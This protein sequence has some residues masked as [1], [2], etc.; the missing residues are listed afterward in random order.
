MDV[1]YNQHASHVRRKNRSTTNL[2][3]LSL[4][5][6]T[7]R[8][9]LDDGANIDDYHPE[10]LS[11]PPSYLQ[12]KSAPTTPRLLSR[13]PGPFP[14]PGAQSASH[15]RGTSTPTALPKAKSTTHLHQSATSAHGPRGPGQRRG[16]TGGVGRDDNPA[17]ADDTDWLLRAGALIY[18]ETRESKGQSWLV[19][20][21]SSVSLAGSDPERAG[22]EAQLAREREYFASRH[23]SRRG[24]FIG[25][26]PVYAS[27]PSAS[28]LGSRSQSRVGSRA[29]LMTPSERRRSVDGYFGHS[30][31]HHHPAQLEDEDDEDASYAAGPDFVSLDTKLEA[32][33]VDTSYEDEAHVR[34][35]VKDGGPSGGN[36]LGSVLRWGLF[37]VEENEEESDGEGDRETTGDDDQGE[38]EAVK[39]PTPSRRKSTVRQFETLPLPAEERVPPPKDDEGGWQDAA[40]LLSVASRVLL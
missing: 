37:S 15:T 7:S 11:A 4:A 2:N 35:L 29:G 26:E 39:F 24:S 6:L 14:R 12:G 23:A 33:E 38:G 28:R 27:S 21:A 22:E 5:P 30:I 8:L 18:T 25:D 16:K 31:H 19:S 10:P 9:P 3:R 32:V 34:R 40:W 36:W 17:A 20:R 1:A 13:S